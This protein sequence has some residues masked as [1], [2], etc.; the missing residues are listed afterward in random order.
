M[1]STAQFSA[2]KSPGIVG[3]IFATLFFG[4]FLG[5]GC[6]FTLLIGRSVWRVLETY[7]WTQADAQI[8]TSSARQRPDAG[9]PGYEFAVEYRYDS[10]RDWLTGT[11]WST[12][13]PTFERFDEAQRIAERFRPGARVPC[14]RDPHD[15]QAAVLERQSPLVGF[16]VLFPLI[17]VA[18][19]AGGIWAVWKKGAPG[20]RTKE[21]PG[22]ERAKA[23]QTGA[24]CLR[25]FFL[26]FFVAGAAALWAMTLGPLLKIAAARSW[27]ATPCRIVS[28]RVAANNDSDGSTYRVDILYAYTFAGMPRHSSRYDFSPGSSSGYAT[29]AAIVGKYPVGVQTTCYVNPRA[30]WE[31]VLRR[32]PFKALWFG[33]IGMV[34][35]GV[36]ALG[37]CHAGRLT[38]GPGRPGVARAADG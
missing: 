33:A 36:G 21:K 13:E 32:E 10:G 1:N 23:N 12:K 17:F 14:W 16:V 35:L 5:M 22:S 20:V 24:G 15:G 29:K 8:V 27:E 18:V 3:K 6:F 2:S 4:V 38:G 30:P 28:S 25:L 26:L 37:A 7:R 31:A 19:G 34:F 9:A 11:R